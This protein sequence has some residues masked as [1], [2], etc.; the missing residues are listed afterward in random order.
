MV[1]LGVFA[2]GLAFAGLT[3][4]A[5]GGAAG[6]GV[7]AAVVAFVGL[8]VWHERVIRRRDR[9]RRSVAYFDRGLARLEDR[10][11][12]GGDD[13]ARFADETHLYSGDL[14]AF[15][16]GS[17][18]HLLST[19]RTEA[20]ASRLAAWLKTPA[21]PEIIRERQLAVRELAEHLE[22]RHDLAVVAPAEGRALDSTSLRSWLADA[23]ASLPGW[24]GPVAATLAALNVSAAA[25]A[26]AGWV[27]G[28]L[29]AVPLLASAALAMWVRPSVSRIL[30]E[31]DR[32][33]RELKVVALLAE[34]VRAERFRSLILS[35][36][37]A[38]LMAPG[39]SPGLVVASLERQVD[40]VDARR[41]QLFMPIA[42]AVLLGTQLACRI[43][44]WRRTFGPAATEWLDQVA[45]LE[46]LASLATHAF[47]H[48]DDA[49]PEI[50]P[51]GSPVEARGLAHALLPLS[52]AVRNDLV[53]GGAIRLVMVSG[54]NMSGKSTLLKA[55]GSNLVLGF[56][57]APVRA[58]SLTTPPLAIGASLVLRDSLLEG[59]SRFYAEVLRLKDIVALADAGTPTLFLLDELLS[60]TNSHDRAIG[61]RGVLEGLVGR[62]A[63]GLVTTHDLA[64]T[65]IATD[66]GPRAV[67]IHLEDRLIAGRL[68]FDYRLKPGVVE[69]TNALE[70]M[71]AVG[72]VTPE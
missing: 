31:A 9:A 1:R 2:A 69:R 48:P 18:F 14:E 8:V 25:A 4:A 15:G 54:S 46:A 60:G 62:G 29:V 51:P 3:I 20:G 63:I 66:L 61:A 67:N 26:L 40:L 55:L 24:L 12:D 39:R 6:W 68:E 70:L 22:L 64:L 27:P 16:R 72:L 57:G 13:G 71:R 7:V 47:E 42:G 10:W 52:R 53:V 5:R 19:T 17:L 58:T 36:L 56:A 65:Q 38:D 49:F 30:A 21:T 50:S 59:R 44:R 28:A 43:E 37:G 34:R 41:N 33:T 32:P 45:D 35:R 11:I 23:P